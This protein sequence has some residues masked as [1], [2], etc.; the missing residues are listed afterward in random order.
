MIG[1]DHPCAGCWHANSE[2]PGGWLCDSCLVADLDNIE[3]GATVRELDEL[4][5]DELREHLEKAEATRAF[6]EGQVYVAGDPRLCPDWE[7]S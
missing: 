4:T 6:F 2:S 1:A 7:P 3:A 5:P